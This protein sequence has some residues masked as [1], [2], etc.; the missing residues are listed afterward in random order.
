[1]IPGSLH[2]TWLGNPI[3][4]WVLAALGAVVGYVVV[5]ALVALLVRHLRRL[6]RLDLGAT[7]AVLA[8]V[9]A[10]T[11]NG[12][13]ALLALAVA[14]KFL[15]LP[16]ALAAHTTQA[17]E[18]VL[19]VQAAF[20]LTRLIVSVLEHLSRRDDAARHTV[21]FGILSWA[22]QL[23]VWLVLVLAVLSNAGLDITA[24]VASLGVGGI[25]VALA[26]QNILGDLFASVSI[27]LDKPFQVGEQIAF[28]TNAG[29]VLHV[30][31]KSTR[32]RANS[33]EELSIAN[34]KLL[35]ELV[36][37]YDRM[38]ERRIVFGFGVALGTSRA[39]LERIVDGVKD[40]I[41]KTEQARLSR[42]HMTA[43]GES[44][45][46]LEF[47]Y[48]VLDPGFERYRDVQQQ[49]NFA[50]LDLLEKLGVRLAVPARV[51]HQPA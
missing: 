42:G 46:D 6:A 21:V 51:L 37:N 34:S 43:F 47:V 8:E 5:R 48:Y 40:I 38:E 30:G 32:I 12:L 28:G 25:A 3:L 16:D 22:A 19:G 18:L 14:A 24:F 15:R 39:D 35:Q 7:V 27:G 36:H 2:T 11:R 41:G 9:V 45:L 20:W 13:I 10:A 44:S 29:T 23:A 4:A 33:G 50:I 1:M 31:V 26:A 49:I 17:I